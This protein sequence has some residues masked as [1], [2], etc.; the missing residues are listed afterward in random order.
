M[1]ADRE[2]V[3]TAGEEGDGGGPAT[4][5]ASANMGSCDPKYWSCPGAAGYKVRG[6]T[7]LKVQYKVDIRVLSAAQHMCSAVIRWACIVR[8]DTPCR[9]PCSC[10]Y[11]DMLSCRLCKADTA[12]LSCIVLGKGTYKGP[13]FVSS[14]AACSCT[15][16]LA[17]GN[18]HDNC[19]FARNL[20]YHQHTVSCLL[21]C[22]SSTSCLLPRKDL[23]QDRQ[24]WHS[25]C[26]CCYCCRYC[27]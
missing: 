17:R 24:L 12:Y 5:D 6:Q 9:T 27:C 26:C 10:S 4:Q 20:H 14:R 2:T 18:I 22:Q 15:C 3:A 11:Q 16:T 7:Y 13:I 1:N 19:A 23:Q 8:S 21:E 25:C